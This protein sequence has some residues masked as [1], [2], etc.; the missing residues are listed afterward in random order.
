MACD[1]HFQANPFPFVLIFHYAIESEDGDQ[2][3]KSRCPI[4]TKPEEPQ[5]IMLH[6]KM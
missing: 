4:E 1:I 2:Q 3:P 5:H 6:C